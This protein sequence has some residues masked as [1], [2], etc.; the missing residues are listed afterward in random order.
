[1]WTSV[2]VLLGFIGFFRL[3]AYIGLRYVDQKPIREA[4]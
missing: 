4:N 1:M 2:Y 3:L